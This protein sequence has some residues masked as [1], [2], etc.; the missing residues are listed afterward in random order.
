MEFDDFDC[1]VVTE[2]SDDCYC[3]TKRN[4]KTKIKIVEFYDDG[5]SKEIGYEGYYQDIP[6][7][8]K[9]FLG[10]RNIVSIGVEKNTLVIGVIC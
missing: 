3:C 10:Y 6:E 7:E 9:N 4:R 2:Y 8:Y 5:A 1:R